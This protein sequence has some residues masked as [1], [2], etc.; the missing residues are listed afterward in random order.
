MTT[1]N[2]LFT[3]FFARKS[4]LA[5]L[6]Y[7]VQAAAALILTI[8][9]SVTS[10][11]HFYDDKIGS[12]HIDAVATFFLSWLLIF[13][14]F[15][16]LAEPICV[17]ISSFHNE[18]INRAQTWRLIP[19]SDTGFYLANTLSS[20]FV[21]IYLVL[22]QLLTCGLIF[23]LIYL[24]DSNVRTA[25]ARLFSGAQAMNLPN[26]FGLMVFSTIILVILFA[27]LWYII[28][29]FYHFAYRSLMDFLPWTNKFW[30]FLVR[31]VTLIIIVFSVNQILN[32]VF[33][34]FKNLEMSSDAALNLQ[35]T[36]MGIAVL[37]LLFGGLNVCLLHNFV[38]AKQ[39]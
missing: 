21:F 36:I 30:L 5:Y 20:F 34:L 28:L 24:A 13:V 37:D 6:I 35:V 25:F 11:F 2:Q 19:I 29:S 1:F 10:G 27:L 26:N 31:L 7:L 39:N 3:N 22:L 18:K 23:G 9:G 32:N 16:W 38:E 15:T 33:G 12:E 8:L 17:L 4:K 14:I